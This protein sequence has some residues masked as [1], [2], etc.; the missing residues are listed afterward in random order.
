MK[1]VK[2]TRSLGNSFHKKKNFNFT[3]KNKVVT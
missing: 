3:L 1:P 2:F